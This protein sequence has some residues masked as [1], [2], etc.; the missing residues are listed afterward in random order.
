MGVFVGHN[1]EECIL[2]NWSNRITQI[3][4]LLHDWKHR[5]LTL[6]GKITIMKTLAISKIAF[7]AAVQSP[8]PRMTEKLSRICHNFLWAKRV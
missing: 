8:P 2:N 3:E 5:D 4:K 7:R 1:K 6:F